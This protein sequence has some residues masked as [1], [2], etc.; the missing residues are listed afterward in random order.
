[1]GISELEAS[2]SEL[3]VP[4]KVPISDEL[5][6]DV[7]S[8]DSPDLAPPSSKSIRVV[9]VG[10]Q[11][12]SMNGQKGVV[13]DLKMIKE[14]YVVRLDNGQTVKVKPENVEADDDSEDDD[15]D[16]V[17]GGSFPPAR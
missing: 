2:G 1:M 4:P 5:P 6:S 16:P 10:L 17:V 12:K 13:E 11:N 3:H 7:I 14:R 8:F 15:D 9:L